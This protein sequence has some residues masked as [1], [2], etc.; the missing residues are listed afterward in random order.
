M[1]EQLLPSIEKGDKLTVKLI[2]K[3]QVKRKHLQVLMKATLLTAMENP[4]KYMGTQDKELAETLIKSGGLGTVATR[5]DI[6]EKLFNS[7]LIEKQVKIF[8]LLLKED[9]YLI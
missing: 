9:N 6:I 8:T 7:F 2:M 1:K 3:H 5:A 4:A